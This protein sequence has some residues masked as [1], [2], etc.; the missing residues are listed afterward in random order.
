MRFRTIGSDQSLGVGYPDLGGFASGPNSPRD[1][2]PGATAER[3]KKLGADI[4]GPLLGML[5]HLR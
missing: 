5:D 4:L 2:D 1:A 3:S